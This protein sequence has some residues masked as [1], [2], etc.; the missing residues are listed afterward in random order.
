MPKRTHKASGSELFIVDNSDDD[1]KALRYLRDWCQLSKSMDIA[2][3]FFEIGSLL[4]LEGEWQKVDKIRI[5]MGDEVSKRTKLSFQKGLKEI[6]LKLDNSLESE[7]TKNHFLSGVPAIVE[8]IRNGKIECRV[9]RKDKFHAKAYITHARMDVVGSSALVGSSNFTF[10]GL[11]E[12]IELNVQITG[13]PVAVLQEWYD[14]HWDDAED[15]TPDLLNVIERHVHEYMPFDIYARSLQQYF[16]GHEETASE[17]EKNNS[18]IYPVLAKYQQNGYSGL[19]KRANRYGGALLC[20]GVGLGKTFIGLMLIERFVVH[21][22][23]NVA[24]FVPKAAK[25]P[26]WE[27]ELQK[28]LPSLFKGYSRLKIFSHTDLMRDKIAEEL[29]QVRQQAHVIII[30]EAHHFRNTGTKGDKEGERRSRYWKLYDIAEG[31]QLF[32]LT[33][34]PINNSLLDFQHMVELFSR[35]EADYFSEAPLGIHSLAGHIRRLEKSIEKQV[36]NRSGGNESLELNF[37]EAGDILSADS[38]FDALVVQRSRSYVKESVS[39]ESGNA[40]LFP[41]PRKPKVVNYS[42]KQ[43]YGKL[44]DMVADAF[45]KKAPL[46]SLPI[47][48]PYAYYIGEDDSV[49]LALEK[50]RRKQVVS[51][52]RTGFLK[53]F[54]S[55]AEAFRQ[56]CWNLLWKLLAWL[57]VHAE[58]DHEKSAVEHWKR[59]NSKL[60]NYEPQFNLVDEQEEDLISPELLDA[61]EKLDRNQFDIEKIIHETVQDLEQLSDFLEELEKFKPSQDKKLTELKKLLKNDP[62]ISKHKVIIFTE[63]SDTASYLYKQLKEAD[64]DGLAQIDGSFKGDRATFI[65]RFAPYYNESSSKE[66]A[67]DGLEEIRVLIST[68]VL[69]EGLNLQD[70]TRIINY[71]LHWNPVRLMQR[72]GRVDRRMNPEIESHII[73]DH[74]DQTKLR[75]TVGYWNFLPPDDLDI[76]LNLYQKVS[77]KTLRISK[78]LGIE[79]RK[80]LTEDDDFDDLKNFTEQYEG[81][82]TPDEEMHLEFQDLL[83]NNEGLEERLNGL[84]NAIFSGKEHIKSGSQAVFFCYSRPAHD[85]QLS[86]DTGED[87]WTADAGDVKWYLYDLK[88]SNI[89]EEPSQIIEF[90]RSKPDT[91]RS[92]KI[93]QVP[94]SD[95]RQ[96]IEKHITKTYLRQVQAP[97]GVKP[98]LKAWMELN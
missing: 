82:P 33:A 19:I 24:L 61:V 91:P 76:L 48:Y 22:N 90:I 79:G 42:V 12:N 6:S 29:E 58:T 26:V 92:T 96:K 87:H 2:T 1:W 88:T 71:D 62:V 40:I 68:D 52:I 51:L 27:R 95:I 31:K 81:R 4:A 13:A 25:A 47:Y 32:H 37:A 17:W 86:E 30:D 18:H 84:P 72:I 9:Y 55:S 11:T 60:I 98:L 44:L 28:R 16:L 66:L 89:I 14:E 85:K 65:R 39:R 83:Q 97:V 34:T 45:H 63:F 53:R 10:P 56:S 69:S 3:G 20:D 93:D 70:A 67:D 73:K 38:L 74:P 94:L 8:A 80:L 54:E 77:H 41:E 64:I 46:F 36:L 50:G 43:T 21:E 15:I 57:D 7:K 49:D 23:K 75:G 35:H 59:R 78:T 5:L